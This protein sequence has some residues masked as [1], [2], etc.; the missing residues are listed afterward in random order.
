MV[1][2]FFGLNSKLAFENFFDREKVINAVGRKTAAA[3]THIGGTTRKTARRSIKK[4]TSTTLH[5]PPG[6]PVRTQTGTYKKAR[7]ILFEYDERK[8]VMICGPVK[9]P[10]KTSIRPQGK[11]TPQLLEEGG[12][13]RASKPVFIRVRA[14]KRKR[15]Q[16]KF[17]WR[18]L[19]KGTFKYKPRPTM[20]LAQAKTFTSTKLRQAFG[21]IGFNTR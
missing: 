21:V 10:K 8:Q 4:A 19:P 16:K 2:K 12:T 5:S 6:K 18:R 7:T 14:K 9:L 20:K 15:G 17:V 11:T 1:K 13:A 3:M